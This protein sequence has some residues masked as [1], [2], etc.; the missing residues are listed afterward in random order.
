MSGYEPTEQDIEGVL[1][2]LKIY[3]PERANREFA[4]A[5]LKHV[6]KNVHNNLSELASDP[7]AFENAV[8]ELEKALDTKFD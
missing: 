8:S 2:Y 4:I 3:K 1:R 5:L 6:S 7:V